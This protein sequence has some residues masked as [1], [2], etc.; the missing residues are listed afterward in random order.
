MAEGPVAAEIRRRLEDAFA[1]QRLEIID[2]SE[3][4]RGHAGWREGGGTHFAVLIVSAAFEGVPRIERQRRIHA[5]LDD[6]L[7]QRVHAL[8]VRALTP[9]EAARGG[10]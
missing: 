2:E 8:S 7:K 1:P 6:L 9:E 4:H 5:L 3:R 10:V